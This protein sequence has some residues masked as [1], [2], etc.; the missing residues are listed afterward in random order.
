MLSVAHWIL[1]SNPPLTAE[2]GT[3]DNCSAVFGFSV[4]NNVTK[5]LF[6]KEVICKKP[7]VALI[8]CE[9]DEDLQ[10]K[11]QHL[12]T[13]KSRKW[14]FYCFKTIKYPNGTR[15]HSGIKWILGSG[16]KICV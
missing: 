13:T 16:A 14:T 15:T 12:R 4:T 2:N 11:K 6:K 3:T 9:L 1:F 8:V 5:T 10:Q 7:Q